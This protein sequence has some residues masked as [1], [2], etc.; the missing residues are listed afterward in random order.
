MKN[1]DAKLKIRSEKLG[2]LTFL[3]SKKD[4]SEYSK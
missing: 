1:L 2:Q 4:L 3:I